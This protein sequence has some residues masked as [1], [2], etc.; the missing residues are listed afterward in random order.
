MTERRKYFSHFVTTMGILN[1][2]S[3]PNLASAK[4]TQAS[5]EQLSLQ[6]YLQQEREACGLKSKTLKV[7]DIVW[8]Y[9]EG[10]SPQK[11]TVLLLHGIASNRDNWNR[12][13]AYLTP[14][15][16]VIVP[17]LPIYGETRVPANFDIAVPNVTSSLRQ[18]AEAIDIENK[19]N[20]A[21]HSLGGSIATLYA[22]QYPFDT[23]SLFLLNS[24][25][26]YKKANTPYTKDPNFLKHLIVAK[27]GDY[28][29]VR[30]EIMQNP[31]K[32]SPELQRAKEQLLISQAG[33]NNLVIEQIS[34]L[35]RIYTPESFA[36]I[37]RNV[38]AP[39]LILWG[40]QDKI[41]NV[42]VADELK[43]LLKRAEA[44]VILNNVGHMPLLEADKQV[45]NYYLPFL[46]KT[47]TLK[48]PLAD[49]LIPLH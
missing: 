2:L 45:A 38:E 12:V 16:H 47:Q 22:A 48:N 39:T 20:I 5:S 26:I 32:L 17:D 18:F 43:S 49:Q 23:Q 21:G 46:A 34:T 44:P 25:G 40:K 3:L 4:T 9:N 7:G 42:E 33:R 8:S 35:N 37:T 13:A 31:P 28:A 29:D 30:Q 36:R 19:L 10:G 11:P 27:P 41:F 24:A 14:N 1:T 6:N 15:Y